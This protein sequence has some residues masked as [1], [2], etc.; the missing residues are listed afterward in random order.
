MPD[1]KV[2]RF[3]KPYADDIVAK[4]ALC[5]ARWDRFPVS[6]GHLLLMPFRHTPDYFSLTA[7]EKAAMVAL[8]DVCREILDENFRPDGYNIGY[9]IGEVAGQS[10]MH[11]HCHFIP[12]YKGD[13]DNPKGGVR[14]VVAGKY[15]N[16]P[17]RKA[18]DK[19]L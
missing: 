14:R 1:A 6:K 3:C 11:C 13:T 7:D 17:M 4:N 5:Y 10:V 8:I 9:N 2:C 15:Y 18:S 19:R 12:R 16:N